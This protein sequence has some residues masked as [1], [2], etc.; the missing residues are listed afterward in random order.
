MRVLEE[1][2]RLK[3]KVIF[4]SSAGVYADLP[5]PQREDGAL[6]YTASTYATSKRIGEELCQLYW[7]RCG[8]PAVALRLFNAYG[9]RGHSVI[10][11]WHGMIMRRERILVDGNGEH[12]RDY[13]HVNDAVDALVS[14]KDYLERN[15]SYDVF[16]VGTGV[17]T[18]LLDLISMMMRVYGITVTHSPSGKPGG[19]RYSR[20]STQRCLERMGFRTSIGLEEGLKMLD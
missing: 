17:G 12:E 8:I 7:R 4:V 3:A 10:N 6:D 14:A 11:T 2:K 16:N 19:V 15:P 20:A 18:K 1:A 5:G 9:P 13:I